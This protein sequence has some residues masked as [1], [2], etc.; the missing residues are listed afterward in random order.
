MS[1]KNYSNN[2]T[3]SSTVTNTYLNILNQYSTPAHSIKGSPKYALKS[4]KQ[5]KKGKKLLSKSIAKDLDSKKRNKKPLSP[6]NTEKYTTN[7]V[8]SKDPYKNYIG[9]YNLKKSKASQ[10]KPNPIK[11][12]IKTP[13]P[14]RVYTDSKKDF[15]WKR[16]GSDP[17]IFMK[18]Y[19][20]NTTGLSD[21]D[22]DVNATS[23]N[24]INR[25]EI[26][27]K[28]TSKHKKK[29]IIVNV[30]HKKAGNL[31]HKIYRVRIEN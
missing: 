7:N 24:H 3:A 8:F 10:R 15:L 30:R 2:G 29:S 19:S 14:E 28:K 11:F 13:S 9:K 22:N 17:G 18:K 12:K 1:I 31:I 25:I 16:S 23:N 26:N 21:A 20:V 4:P 5:N 6:K 27:S